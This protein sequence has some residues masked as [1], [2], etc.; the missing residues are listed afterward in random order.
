[1]DCPSALRR[2]NGIYTKVSG[3]QSYCDAWMSC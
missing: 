2:E 3:K 1:L